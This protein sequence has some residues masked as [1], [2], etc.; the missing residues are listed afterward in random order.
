MMYL[1]GLKLSSMLNT[2]HG[3]EG[4]VIH[5]GRQPQEYATSTIVSSRPFHIDLVRGFMIVRLAKL[6]N[7]FLILLSLS[8]S[9][10]SDRSQ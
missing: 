4:T 8:L 3:K 9:Q 5:I 6:R 7:V 1:L 2:T 10:Q